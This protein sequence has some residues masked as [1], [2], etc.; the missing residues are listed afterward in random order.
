MIHQNLVVGPLACNCALLA[1]EETREAVLIDP[2]DEA[3]R[4]LEA[5]AKANVTVKY[6]L[7]THAHFDHVGATAGVRAKLDAKTCLHRGDED[8]YRN[9]PLQGRMFGVP[10]DAAPPLEKYLEDNEVLAFGRYRIEVVHTPGHSPGSVCFRVTGDGQERLF[11]GDTLFQGSIGRADL[12]GGDGRQ[13]I[14]S[15]KTR[16]LAFDDEIPVYP[17]HGEATKIGTERR[18]NPFLT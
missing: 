18:S 10:M 7:H 13:L 9:L 15:I 17:G 2:G 14:R 6:L 16:L 4:I 5:V 3:P 12:W 11:S 8:L 1:C